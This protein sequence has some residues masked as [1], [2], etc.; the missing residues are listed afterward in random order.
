MTAGLEY[1][2]NKEGSAVFEVVLQSINLN[3]RIQGK[4]AVRKGR[5]KG[6]DCNTEILPL[7][8]KQIPNFIYF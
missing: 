3:F 8:L 1:E 7:I 2:R 4:Y 6:E 5:L